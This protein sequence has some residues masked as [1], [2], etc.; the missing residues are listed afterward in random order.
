MGKQKDFIIKALL[1]LVY[2]LLVAGAVFNLG[3]IQIFAFVV[4][5]FFVMSS[6][7]KVGMAQIMAM[8]PNIAV[9]SISSIGL[10]GLAFAV[11]LLKISAD[12]KYGINSKTVIIII[13]AYLLLLSIIRVFNHNYYDFALVIQVAIVVIT[14]TSLLRKT[15][16]NESLLYIDYFRYGCLLM[17]L[18]MLISY[19][20]QD[21]AIGRFKGVLDDCNYT[22]AVMCVLFAI[23]L[24]SYCY[25]LPL[26]HNTFYMIVALLMGLATGSRG[27][28][29]STVIILI[30]LLLTK[31]FSK[32]SAK[33]VMIV[34]FLMAVT[35]IMYLYNF[36]PL[37]TFYN[38]TI[39]RTVELQEGHVDGNFMDVTSGRSILWAYYMDEALKDSDILLW[40]RGF[41]NYHTESNGGFGLAAHNMYLSS[42]IGIGIIATILVLLMYYNILKTGFLRKHHRINIA[43][44]SIIVAL[45]TNYFFL[46][47]ML[48]I[49]LISYHAMVV[50]MMMIY[51]SIHMKSV[52]KC[53]A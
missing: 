37:M 41:Y 45:L 12:R 8:V 35:Y 25:N 17:A 3:Y 16:Y 24:L 39:E 1:L 47:G 27:F 44:S 22:G 4:F 29:L 23:S 2:M 11:I 18:G 51:K 19:P 21:N 52:V 42:I 15:S 6:S 46:D 33:T 14:W 5:L 38:N 53:D 50:L 9:L 32:K 40:G 31:S 7:I 49:R 36:G 48:E 43:F 30:I 34:L 13:L 20:L 28:L 10:L 26:K